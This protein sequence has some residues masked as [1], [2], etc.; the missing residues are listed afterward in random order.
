MVLMAPLIR[1][2]LV[3]LAAM[4]AAVAFSGCVRQHLALADSRQLA[5]VLGAESDDIQFINF[6]LFWLEED[7]EHMWKPKNAG[8]VALTESHLILGRGAPKEVDQDS[9]WRIPLSEVDGVAQFGS[10]LQFLCQGKRVI[11]YPFSPHPWTNGEGR[12]EELAVMLKG[13]FVPLIE[14]VEV[15]AIDF[16][17]RTKSRGAIW[18]DGTS[19]GSDSDS[20]FYNGNGSVNDSPLNRSLN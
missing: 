16:D 12:L 9:L 15:V 5:P 13:K 14:P 8:F 6:A 17:Q 4:I 7:K 19:D 3:A 11:V 18:T 20:F 2:F 1:Y 10:D